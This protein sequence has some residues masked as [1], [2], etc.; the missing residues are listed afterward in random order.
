V[1]LVAHGGRVVI[2]TGV[3]CRWKGW[4]VVSRSVHVWVVPCWTQA[5]GRGMWK[6]GSREGEEVRGK[7]SPAGRRPLEED[8][9]QD[10]SRKGERGT[11]KASGR[12]TVGRR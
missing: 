6:D 10:C 8:P 1:T 3:S 2:L 5:S 12:G 7:G 9:W 11:G 4:K